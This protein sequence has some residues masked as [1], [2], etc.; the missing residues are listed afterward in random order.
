MAKI[1]GARLRARLWA[2]PLEERLALSLILPDEINIRTIDGANNNLTVLNPRTLEY[3]QGAAD[4]RQIR[5]GYG[6]EF[7]E[8]DPTDIGNV[9]VGPTTSPARP[10]ARTLSN[11]LFAQSVDKLN[12]RHLTDWSFQWGQWVTHDMDLTFNGEE[13]DV[14][15][16]ANFLP[17]PGSSG[18][19]SIAI[20][21]PLDPL[22]PNPIPF[23]RSAVD[24]TSA[25]TETGGQR[26]P[27]RHQ[28]NA[29]TSYIDASNVY[30]S[31]ATRAAA[32]RTFEGG[33]LRTSAN[34]Q[35]LP[36]NDGPNPL[37]NADAL[38]LG[39]ALFLAGDF[40]ANEQLNLTAVHT[41]FVREHNRLAD[42]IH[43]LYP[44]LTDEEIFQVA[45][46]IVG[47]EQQVI[48]Y[49]EYLPSLFGY[50]LA[51]D[52]DDAVYSTSVNASVTNSFA[53][54][55][56]R[57]GHSQI[58]DA[59]LLVNNFN[60]SVGSLT[61][62]DAFFNPE[63]LKED[64]SRV[65]R[66]LKGLASQLGQEVDLMLVNGIRNN[67]FGP[68]GF[69]GLDLGALDV[70]RGRDH[71]LPDYNNL[72]GAYGVGEITSFAQITSNTDIQAALAAQFGNVDN[73]DPFVGMLAEDHLPGMSV[74]PTLFSI[75]N[76]Q[77]ARLRDG[78]RFFYTDDAFLNSPGV[79]AVLDMEDVTLANIIRWNTQIFN[80]QDNVFF[81]RSVIVIEAPD[82]G[83]NLSVVAGLGVVSVIDNRT[84]QVL[85]L[86]TLGNVSQIILVGSDTAP[87]FFN[88][89]IAGSNGGLEDGIVAYGGNGTGDILNVYGRAL[90]H[91][92][93][94][95]DNRSFTTGTVNT[96]GVD[97]TVGV[98]GATVDVNGNSI[99]SSGFEKIRIV[100]LGGDDSVTF[101]PSIISA[102]VEVVNWHNPF[103]EN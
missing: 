61:V 33:K 65:G 50:D 81:D 78:D 30:G 71:G 2:E 82:E 23:H 40:R 29:I 45:R 77:F 9:L 7:T 64:P 73:I 15:L 26:P 51:A 57:F 100:T 32:L 97:I 21:D 8:N 66:M 19:Y 91:D 75:V 53:H 44:T 76:N 13:F 12:D 83:A 90:Q 34:G 58:N 18:E 80:I 5:F 4:T 48:T 72:R 102:I 31:D 24:F 99:V 46:R 1:R 43:A 42:R 84:N 87:D 59:T 16:D 6:V 70:Q 93:F 56:F 55:A 20:E 74:G 68:A 86:N 28:I 103:D 49:E 85:A 63:F 60:Q 95:V 3:D 17:I 67:L 47:A 52:P 62:D 11:A 54:A 101:D 25:Q 10:N 22:G 79:K 69:G 98:G 35:L 89:F 37:P 92:S 39:P 38:G 14:L 88:L 27:R 41:L 36:L 96:L 94:D